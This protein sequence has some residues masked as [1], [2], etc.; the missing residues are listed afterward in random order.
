ML[1]I[2]G[3]WWDNQASS[4]ESTNIHLYNFTTSESGVTGMSL[5]EGLFHLYLALFK[6]CLIEQ[7]LC[8]L[9]QVLICHDN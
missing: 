2:K 1:L 4:F 7:N 5:H 9:Y 8:H 6:I 3:E